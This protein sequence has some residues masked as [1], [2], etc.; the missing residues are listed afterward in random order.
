MNNKAIAL[1]PRV[2]EKTYGLSE[3]HNVYVFEA[4]N[5]INKHNV[6]KAVTTQFGVTV[7]KVNMS[8]LK[9][10]AK[11]TIR[12]GGR[13]VEQG[14]QN[15]VKKAYVTLKEGDN[16]AIFKAIDEEEQSKPE[17]TPKRGKK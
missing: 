2:S 3:Q 13:R 8:N 11:R 10:K 4:P 15:N 17:Q 14:R 5:G 1:K 12:Q 7:V 9:G 6:A 16:I